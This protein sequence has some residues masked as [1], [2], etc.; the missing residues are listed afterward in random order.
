MKY[1]RTS[2]GRR[3]RSAIQFLSFVVTESGEKFHAR[4]VKCCQINKTIQTLMGG[5]CDE[6]TGLFGNTFLL[7]YQF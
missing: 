6:R 3:I 5:T 1:V 2:D 4:R 7:R